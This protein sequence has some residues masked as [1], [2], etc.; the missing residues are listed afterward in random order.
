MMEKMGKGMAQ[1]LTK[2]PIHCML[3]LVHAFSKDAGH[4]MFFV[5][6]VF[7]L[8]NDRLTNNTFVLA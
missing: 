8:K 7:G 4:F 3:P 5:V 2:D 6:T 1:E